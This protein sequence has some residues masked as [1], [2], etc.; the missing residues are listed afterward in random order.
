MDGIHRCQILGSKGGTMGV[1]IIGPS[2]HKNS[3]AKVG[4]IKA[5]YLQ[6]N[7]ATSLFGRLRNR[8]FSRHHQ[9]QH[10]EILH[11]AV[12]LL[13]RTDVRSDYFPTQN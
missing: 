12:H 4:C 7:L 3:S 11:T 9:I 8:G 5:V 1:I 2:L 6:D 10:S 13:L